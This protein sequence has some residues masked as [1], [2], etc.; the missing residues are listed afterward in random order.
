V[1]P[2]LEESTLQLERGDE[3][4]SLEVLRQAAR[5]FAEDLRVL[6]AL[7]EALARSGRTEEARRA[8]VSLYEQTEDLQTR[9]RLLGPLAEMSRAEGQLESLL[10]EF[11]ARQR[12]NR[13]SAAPWMALAEIHRAVNND[14]ERRRCLYEASRMRPKDLVLLTEIARCEE[15]SGLTKEALRTLQTAATLDQTSATKQDIARLMIE[16]GDDEAGYRLLLE[17]AG[18]AGADARAFEKMADTMCE[19]GDWGRAVR[20]LEPLLPQFP[21]D[22]RLRYLHATALEQE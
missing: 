15:E 1:Q 3:S 11:Q 12:Q 4:A 2:W 10:E 8:Y 18:G 14:E 16:S 19:H 22:Y 5:K 21:G 17:L 13:G 9:L 20:F 7:A 6:T